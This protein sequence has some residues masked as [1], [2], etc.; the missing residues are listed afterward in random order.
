A[1][2]ALLEPAPEQVLAA[3]WHALSRDGLMPRIVQLYEALIASCRRLAEVL[4]PE[5]VFELEHRTALAEFG[6]RLA[7]RQVLQAAAWLEATLPRHRLRP[8]LRRQEVPTRVLDED[9]Y[10]VG[11]FAS[12]ATR[13]SI[14]SLLHSQLVFMEREGR[15]DLF[16]IKYLRDELL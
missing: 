12:V 6:Q 15:P 5:D 3:G 1:L 7:L 8:P 11:G 4:A 2:K 13:G 14:E 16:D 10:P 9:T